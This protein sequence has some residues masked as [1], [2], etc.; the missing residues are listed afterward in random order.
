M[1][2]SVI[3]GLQNIQ[4]YISPEVIITQDQG[5]EDSFFWDGVE[6]YSREKGIPHVSLSTASRNLMWIASLDSKALRCK[7]YSPS[8]ECRVRKYSLYVQ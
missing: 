1:K 5:W 6:V 4:T 8:L 3:G 7:L 2:R